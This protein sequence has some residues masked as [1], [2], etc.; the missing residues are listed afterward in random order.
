MRSSVLNSEVGTRSGRI[1]LRRRKRSRRALERTS[2]SKLAALTSTFLPHRQDSALVAT[3]NST[4]DTII[5]ADST[6]RLNSIYAATLT[7]LAIRG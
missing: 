6:S 2:Q 4:Q 1:G 5:N 7:L 3:R